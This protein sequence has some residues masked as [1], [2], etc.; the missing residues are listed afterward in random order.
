[1]THSILEGADRAAAL[2]GTYLEMKLQVLLRAFTFI[3]KPPQITPLFMLPVEAD[4]QFN[5]IYPS[6]EVEDRAK[7]WKDW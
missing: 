7:Q 6:E 5:Y 1:M 4:H 3:Q 2:R